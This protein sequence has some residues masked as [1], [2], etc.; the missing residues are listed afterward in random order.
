MGALVIT[1][2]FLWIIAGLAV[3]CRKNI[4]FHPYGLYNFTFLVYYPLGIILHYLAVW[5]GVEK[6]WFSS[7]YTVV[8]NAL[9]IL[10][11]AFLFF[12]VF[13]AS[14]FLLKKTIR[15]KS[16]TVC[17]RL[18]FFISRR[19]VLFTWLL[20]VLAVPLF[21][22]YLRDMGGF[23]ILRE[24]YS[25]LQEAKAGRGVIKTILFPLLFFAFSAA[26]L[27]LKIKSRDWLA[28]AV[29]IALAGMLL[30][31]LGERKY[32]V[33]ILLPLVVYELFNRQLDF[34]KIAVIFLCLLSLFSWGFI[35]GAGV[36]GGQLLGLIQMDFMP[37]V[38]KNYLGTY[39]HLEPLGNIIYYRLNEEYE[40]ARLFFDHVFYYTPRFLYPDKPLVL[41]P[42]SIIS[43]VF[44]LPE[45][46]LT[47]IPT[48]VGEALIACNLAGLLIYPVLHAAIV[49]VVEK[50]LWAKVGKVELFIVYSLSLFI[51][52]RL[53]RSGVFGF[54]TELPTVVF[55]LF[56][57][58]CYYV[59]LKFTGST[60]GASHRRV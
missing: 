37:F 43:G 48:S 3:I 15:E 38:L 33:I 6:L 8:D 17:D 5:I 44:P 21:F 27:I 16:I 31:T 52:I 13:N 59:F 45:E 7:P 60:T 28:Y 53:H 56:I 36:P 23:F 30:L 40:I 4:V 50:L 29:G 26:I 49:L 11:Y 1:S 57:C 32:S 10:F 25:L 19:F 47:S 9:L 51:I 14:Y 2:S 34:K 42:Q 22:L 46:G 18:D 24:G 20:F 55:L 54:F 41:G 12:A 39:S 35:R 58:V